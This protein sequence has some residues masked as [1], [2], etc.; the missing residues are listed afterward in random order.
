MWDV[1]SS[2]TSHRALCPF[3]LWLVCIYLRSRRRSNVSTQRASKCIQAMITLVPL[4]KEMFSHEFSTHGMHG[5]SLDVLMFS[6]FKL[7]YSYGS[8]VGVFLRFQSKASFFTVLNTE[9]LNNVDI[10]IIITSPVLLQRGMWDSAHFCH[11]KALLQRAFSSRQG[12]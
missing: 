11:H 8:F 1:D 2:R 5:K 9:R 12:S 6:F 10:T 4:S 7:I 3:T